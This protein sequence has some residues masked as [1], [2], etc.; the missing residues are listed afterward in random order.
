VD[1][2][3]INVHTGWSD[4][5]CPDEAQLSALGQDMSD[6]IFAVNGKFYT[7]QKSIGLYPTSGTA[8]DWYVGLLNKVLLF[9][10]VNVLQVLF[11]ECK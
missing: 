1:I 8:S 11:R 7:S 4:D 9:Q 3:S 6:R 5:D 10:I 2:W